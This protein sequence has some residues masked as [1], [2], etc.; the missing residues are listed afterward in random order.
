VESSCFRGRARTC[1]YDAAHLASAVALGAGEAILVTWAW[2][3]PLPA[4]ALRSRPPL[5]TDRTGASTASEDVPV[6]GEK[7]GKADGPFRSTPRLGFP[8]RRRACCFQAFL[9]R[10]RTVTPSEGTATVSCAG[11]AASST[12]LPATRKSRNHA[13]FGHIRIGRSDAGRTARASGG[14][15]LTTRRS[16]ADVASRDE[17]RR[18][19]WAMY[20]HWRA[21][22]VRRRLGG[23]GRART[24]TRQSEK[25][26]LAHRANAVA[27]GQAT[28]CRAGLSA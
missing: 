24:G 8:G 25:R 19:L 13:G 27:V 12:V 4:S 10:T 5:I 9:R 11:A 23:R 14:L 2:A 16:S 1:G 26:G 15:P 6:T 18:P 20:V 22:A 7:A 17:Q 28:T 21:G 3:A